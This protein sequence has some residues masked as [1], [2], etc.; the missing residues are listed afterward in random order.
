MCLKGVEPMKLLE[1]HPP[2]KITVLILEQIVDS[3]YAKVF[4]NSNV[5]FTLYFEAR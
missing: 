4:R 2:K 3:K 5:K 1:A